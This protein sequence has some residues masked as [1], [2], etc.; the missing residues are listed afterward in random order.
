M[1]D[2]RHD[3]LLASFEEF[4]GFLFSHDIAMSESTREIGDPWYWHADVEYDAVAVAEYYI[5]LF[6]D[7]KFLLSGFSKEQLEQGFWAI[8]CG[9]IGCAVAEII[10]NKDVP[11]GTR[12]RC[13]RSMFHLFEKLF[14]LDPLDTSVNM[15]WDAL[16]Y[17]WHCNNRVRSNGGEDQVMQDVMFETLERILALPDEA[18]QM[19]A[20]HGLGHLHH[21]GTQDLI[22]RYL[23]GNVSL[24][25]RDYAQAA[26]RFEVL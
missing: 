3:I 1:T 15:W 18:C 23:Q 21:P 10:W 12:E 9:N 7:P 5:R 26:A 14:V 22:G 25:L 19:S 20:L 17:D 16:A 2:I 8:L 4:V 11:F 6:S 24:R 13:V